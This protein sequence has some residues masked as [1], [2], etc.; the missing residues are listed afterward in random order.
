MSV[1]IKSFALG[2]SHS[3]R[4]KQA[5]DN[6]QIRN[7]AAV[8]QQAADLASAHA[9]DTQKK[10]L[11]IK[12][13]WNT[14]ESSKDELK[15]AVQHLIPEVVQKQQI[16]A[17]EEMKA[18]EI[19]TGEKAQ[20]QYE[21]DSKYDLWI[22]QV[23]SLQDNWTGM[24]GEVQK[25]FEIQSKLLVKLK[26]PEYLLPPALEALLFGKTIEMVK[27]ERQD[28]LDAL[29][30]KLADGRQ[31]TKEEK[32]D[33][34]AAVRRT[35]AQST[36]SLI[37]K[38]FKGHIGDADAIKEILKA[39]ETDSSEKAFADALQAV[40]ESKEVDAQTGLPKV[41]ES[42]DLIRT[43]NA[44]ALVQFE[45]TVKKILLD[46][47]R[48]DRAEMDAKTLCNG[49]ATNYAVIRD[50]L[51]EKFAKGKAR[52]VAS[53][54]ALRGF[55][56]AQSVPPADPS[57]LE[58]AE[59]EIK[60]E[61]ADAIKS[62]EKSKASNDLQQKLFDPL[63]DI[64]KVGNE[65]AT[66]TIR[67]CESESYCKAIKNI[68]LKWKEEAEDAE[69]AELEKKKTAPV[70]KK[71]AKAALS[72]RAEDL[73]RLLIM[74]DPEHGLVRKSAN[75][76]GEFSKITLKTI[77]SLS[78][79][80]RVLFE[81]KFTTLTTD[82]IIARVQAVDPDSDSASVSQDGKFDE[83][84]PKYEVYFKQAIQKLETAAQAANV[85]IRMPKEK[86]EHILSG[87]G[88]KS[89][90]FSLKTK[91]LKEHEEK[92]QD[93]KKSG[94]EIPEKA[95][96]L[97]ER[98]RNEIL[99]AKEGFD[100]WAQRLNTYD[101]LVAEGPDAGVASLVKN[102]NNQVENLQKLT[103]KR[104]EE[105]RIEGKSSDESDLEIAP[106][107]VG[108]I[109]QAIGRMM[110]DDVRPETIKA[111]AT[112]E[113]FMLK[114]VP[115]EKLPDETKAA[116]ALG[117]KYE[118]KIL[119][120]CEESLRGRHPGDHPIKRGNV[121]GKIAVEEIIRR[122]R[123]SPE[124][125]EILGEEKKETLDESDIEHLLQNVLPNELAD[126][127]VPKEMVSSLMENLAKKTKALASLYGHETRAKWV[128][129]VASAG[130]RDAEEALKEALAKD[131][132]MKFKDRKVAPEN[133]EAALNRMMKL[134]WPNL[135]ADNLTEETPKLTLSKEQVAMLLKQVEP[136]VGNVLPP[137]PITSSRKER[138]EVL[139][140]LKTVDSLRRIRREALRRVSQAYRSD[141][142]NQGEMANVN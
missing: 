14:I 99:F 33:W 84:I 88:E 110:S 40:C 70:A 122:L 112:F 77:A 7:D 113:A 50:L 141:G 94:S 61:D 76:L 55:C 132:D 45:E 127:G 52:K 46:S 97:E 82:Q 120:Y 64:Q 102:I 39:F 16:P 80:A 116:V 26:N 29:A 15:R 57:A 128:Q 72:S 67:L 56:F 125:Q 106:R 140:A 83:I 129:V 37:A 48:K 100:D 119:D 63:I 25:Q 5:D 30:Q 130:G 79:D 59:K 4:V 134:I 114:G 58:T 51:S 91:A 142:S 2:A 89:R 22:S 1:V 38:M 54:Q 47:S 101:D 109:K 34:L 21:K 96:I 35:L 42:Y 3:P 124:Y 95:G 121:L 24:L 11:A 60:K 13:A 78:N 65:A 18:E 86:I 138:R 62:T 111:L 53:I 28:R 71:E 118:N 69:R 139:R 9:S 93:I 12:Q 123:E 6:R 104:I 81:G 74:F 44:K 31:L 133:R 115:L 126:K 10:Q 27:K 41:Y 20:P 90:D 108:A 105:M 32:D 36:P 107:L 137:K 19:S 66:D 68:A 49:L 43:N 87:L 135:I 8:L 117:E 131:F 136:I 85:K 23:N 103:A 92:T 75:L 17:T 73:Q 98:L